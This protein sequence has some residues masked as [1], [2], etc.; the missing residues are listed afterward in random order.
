M[1]A[2][3]SGQIVLWIRLEHAQ[4]G[5]APSASQVNTQMS[6]LGESV[7]DPVGTEPVLHNHQDPVAVL[8]VPH[9]NAVAPA[10][11]PAHRL[12]DECVL[13]SVGRS[14][15][16]GDDREV[17]DRVRDADYR[18]RKFHQSPVAAQLIFRLQIALLLDTTITVISSQWERMEKPKM[19]CPYNR[20]IL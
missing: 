10:G 12:D 6:V 1:D 17:R 3:H 14:R 18:S 5:W 11:T 19:A 16:A 9:R 15:Y 7:S 20:S 13:A 8:E 2:V 4:P